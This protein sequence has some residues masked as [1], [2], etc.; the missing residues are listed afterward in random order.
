MLACCIFSSCSSS[1]IIKKDGLV[2]CELSN[3]L[4]HK[5]YWNTHDTWDL[6]SL[7][8]TLEYDDGSIYKL[9]ISDSSISYTV[10]PETTENLGIYQLSVD[11]VVYTDYKGFKHEVEGKKYWIRVEECPYKYGDN[12]LIA[13]KVLIICVVIFSV[14]FLILFIFVP[15]F[16]KR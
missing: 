4:E 6:S 13:K 15:L 2:S 10:S 7:F 3:N 14:S 9:P 11:N 5:I 1:T 12:V 8:I 16:K